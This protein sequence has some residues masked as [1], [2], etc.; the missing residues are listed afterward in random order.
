MSHFGGNGHLRVSGRWSESSQNQSAV[1]LLRR[2][3]DFSF[4][5]CL[6]TYILRLLEGR[7]SG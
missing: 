5:E 7:Y 3:V 6:N 2:H 1:I 4:Q